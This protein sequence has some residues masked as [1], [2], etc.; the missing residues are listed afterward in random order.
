[1]D[2]AIQLQTSECDSAALAQP[3]AI[4]NATVQPESDTT[5]ED[6]KELASDP[7]LLDRF[8]ADLEACGLSGET[9][10]AKILYLALTSRCVPRR[11]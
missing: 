4:T 11:S 7:A 1:M 5:W 3:S 2:L 8:A 9:R 10:N 6:C